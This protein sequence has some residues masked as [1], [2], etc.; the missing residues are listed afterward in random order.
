MLWHTLLW[1]APALEARLSVGTDHSAFSFSLVFDSEALRKKEGWKEPANAERPTQSMHSPHAPQPREH[2]LEEDTQGTTHEQNCLRTSCLGITPLKPFLFSL[3]DF[4]G[5]FLPV[6]SSV[7][8]LSV[9]RVTFHH[10][11]LCEWQIVFIPGEVQ[12]SS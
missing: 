4:M 8:N 11:G 9:L 6:L 12:G 10:S 7:A 2:M 5:L 1:G 3:W